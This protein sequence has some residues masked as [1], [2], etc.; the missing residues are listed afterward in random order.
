[1]V[2][3]RIS[4]LVAPRQGE[5][6]LDAEE[7]EGRSPEL[8][9]GPFRMDDAA[10]RR[11]QVDLARPDRQGGAEAVAMVDLAIEQVA[12]GRKPDMRM[13]PDVHPLPKQEFGR[14][15]LIEEDEG[16]DHLATL[17]RQGAPHA[18]AAEIL[19]GRHDDLLDGIAGMGVA[20]NGI[21]GG[22]LGHGGGELDGSCSTIGEGF[23]RAAIG[24]RAR[25]ACERP[26]PTR[27]RCRCIRRGPADRSHAPAAAGT[28]P[29]PCHREARARRRAAP[30]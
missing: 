2:E 12:H 8:R 19:G 3:A 23:G 24:S 13:R 15:E 22:K 18:E 29:C 28:D 25:R 4:L 27:R 1:M 9:R 17:R 14:A 26:A 20:R 7:L 6:G 16:P 11:H 21:V 10:A 5:P 30:A